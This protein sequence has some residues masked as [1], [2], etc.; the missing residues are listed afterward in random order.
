MANEKDKSKEKDME[1]EY[2]ALKKKYALPDLKELDREFCIGKLEDKPFFLRIIINKM[3]ERLE[4]VFKTLS[5]IVQPSESSLSAMYEAEVFSDDE[6]KSIFDLMKK[7]A[8]YHRELVIQDME[9]DDASAADMIN[10]FFAAWKE[11]KKEVL[12]IMGKLRD[13][14]KNEIKSKSETEYFG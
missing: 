2:E 5:D 1:K 6:K 10:K 9:Y 14:W 3:T 12:K 4:N 11:M 8:Y 13:S 7:M